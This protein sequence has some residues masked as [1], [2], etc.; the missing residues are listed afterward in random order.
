MISGHLI[1][2]MS[3]KIKEKMKRFKK[4]LKIQEFMCDET[5]PIQAENNVKYKAFV[6]RPWKNKMCK[7]TSMW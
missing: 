2:I 6:I 1:E 5:N 4:R 3:V 7:L